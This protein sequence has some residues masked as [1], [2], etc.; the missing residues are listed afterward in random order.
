MPCE[1]LQYAISLFSLDG[2]SC[3]I[4]LGS[5]L[6]KKTVTPLSMFLRVFSVKLSGELFEKESSLRQ[7]EK[8]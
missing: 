8:S 2:K 1:I 3:T 6:W 7:E 4:Q 5:I